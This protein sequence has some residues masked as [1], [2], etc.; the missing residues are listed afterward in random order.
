MDVT[1]SFR[2]FVQRYDRPIFQLSG[3]GAPMPIKGLRPRQLGP[4]ESF[5]DVHER[6]WLS[7]AL[8]F[9]YSTR[10]GTR[11]LSRF[12]TELRTAPDRGHR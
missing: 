5:E 3:G 6:R 2:D 8:G 9:I 1:W 7:D 11:T 12:C 4:P 10:Q